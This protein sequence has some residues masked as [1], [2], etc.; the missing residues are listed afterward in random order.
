MVTGK[1]VRIRRSELATMVRDVPDWEVPLLEALW[2]EAFSVDRDI[3]MRREPPASAEAE[4]KRLVK[5]YKEA[6]DEKGDM[7]GVTYAAA[8]YGQFGVGVKAL[9]RAIEAATLPAESD[10]S[11]LL[12]VA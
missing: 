1:R 9:A 3:V 11:D 4:Y 6:L 10:V 2:A 8:V 7:T 5:V 12:C